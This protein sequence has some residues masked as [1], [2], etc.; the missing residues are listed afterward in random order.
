MP[1]SEKV[2][3]AFTKMV[4]RARAVSIAGSNIATGVPDDDTH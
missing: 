4:I 3:A 1:T 2:V